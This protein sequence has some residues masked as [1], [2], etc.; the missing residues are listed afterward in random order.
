[1]PDRFHRRIYVIKPQTNFD[2]TAGRHQ[3]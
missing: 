3:H 2:A 1:M